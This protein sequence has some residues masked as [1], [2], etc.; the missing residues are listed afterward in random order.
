V[1]LVVKNTGW[2]P[3]YVTKRALANKL[4]RGVVCEIELPAHAR[5]EQGE[6]RVE[7]VQLEGRA[8]APIVPTASPWTGWHGDLTDDRA[9]AE[10]VVAAPAGTLVKLTAR[11]DRAGVTRREIRLG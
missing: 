10:W 1:R 9:K 6:R 2:L 3:S 11:H 7:L 8:Y 5:L 4:T